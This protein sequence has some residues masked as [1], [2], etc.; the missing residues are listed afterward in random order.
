MDSCITCFGGRLYCRLPRFDLKIE[1]EHI[2]MGDKLKDL[3]EVR[4]ETKVVISSAKLPKGL[5]E[6]MGRI[7]EVVVPIIEQAVKEQ[8]LGKEE[9]CDEKQTSKE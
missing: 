3:F 5:T 9:T 6:P 4:F 7:V 8:L 2:A 1:K